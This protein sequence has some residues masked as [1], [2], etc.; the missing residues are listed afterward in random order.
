MKIYNLFAVKLNGETQLVNWSSNRYFIY[1]EYKRLNEK[2]IDYVSV[3]CFVI[4]ITEHLS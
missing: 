2:I 4:S 3:D 1:N